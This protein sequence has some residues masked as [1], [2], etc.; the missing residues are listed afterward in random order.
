MAPLFLKKNIMQY[1]PIILN[2][3]KSMVCIM[4]KEVG[5]PTFNILPTV[6]RCVADIVN[7]K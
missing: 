2:H 4:D 7:G 5:E 3:T 6:N 1:F